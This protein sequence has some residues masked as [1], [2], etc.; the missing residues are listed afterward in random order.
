[1]TFTIGGEN[2]KQLSIT[3]DSDEEE[4]IHLG[5]EQVNKITLK[6]KDAEKTISEVLTFLEQPTEITYSI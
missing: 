3:N 6:Y 4:D 2:N 1:L 5:Q